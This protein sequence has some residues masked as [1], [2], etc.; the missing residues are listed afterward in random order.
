MCEGAQYARAHNLR[1]CVRKLR[2]RGMCVSAQFARSHNWRARKFCVSAQCA[3]RTMCVRAMC[4][5]AQCV[6]GHNVAASLQY[7][8]FS[9]WPSFSLGGGVGQAEVFGY[10]FVEL[11]L[12]NSTVGGGAYVQP[13][14]I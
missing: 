6:C 4:V 9:A 12:D 5:R 3:W 10:I 1:A 2:S 14:D 7:E 13:E 8:I 11:D